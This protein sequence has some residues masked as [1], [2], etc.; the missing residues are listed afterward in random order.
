MPVSAGS[1]GQYPAAMLATWVPWVPRSTKKKRRLLCPLT[2]SLQDLSNSPYCLP[3]NSVNVNLENLVLD[4]PI[5]PLLIFFFIFINCLL[6][7]VSIPWGEI[8]FWSLMG[9]RG[10]KTKS[11]WSQ[12]LNDAHIQTSICYYWQY[13][14]FF[15]NSDTVVE[16]IWK[17]IQALLL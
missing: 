10:L 13:F 15:I 1:S 6:D 2:L 3:Y 5:F 8:L 7:I 17:I 11:P 12:T 9:A 4:Q 16:Q 14:A